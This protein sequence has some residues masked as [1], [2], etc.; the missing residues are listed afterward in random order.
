M[1]AI[2][3]AGPGWASSSWQSKEADMPGRARRNSPRAGTSRPRLSTPA[4]RSGVSSKLT[5]SLECSATGACEGLGAGLAPPSSP[6][7]H[8]PSARSSAQGDPGVD[9]LHRMEE[10]RPA[11][12]GPMATVC[13]P[14]HCQ[15]S[16]CIRPM[17]PGQGAAGWMSNCSPRGMPAAISTMASTCSAASIPLNC[18]PRACA[19]SAVSAD[20]MRSA[21]SRA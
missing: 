21:R 16:G 18:S 7:A 10:Q 6:G 8:G 3:G 15:S 12:C 11:G 13:V 1:R 17:G 9:P 5:P 20:A 14:A 2:L 19:S 4:R